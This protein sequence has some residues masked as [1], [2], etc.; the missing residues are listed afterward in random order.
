M[1]TIMKSTG[2]LLTILVGLTLTVTLG[3]IAVK[4]NAQEAV[5]VVSRAKNKVDRP[6]F[7]DVGR[8]KVQALGDMLMDANIDVIYAMGRTGRRSKIAETGRR[9]KM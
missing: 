8:K 9:S 6:E 3:A 4:A 7:T 2:L 5:F 1:K